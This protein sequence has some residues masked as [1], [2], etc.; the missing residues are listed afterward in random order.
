MADVCGPW[1]LEQLDQFG[2]LDSLPFS[3]DSDVWLTA[4]IRDGSGAVT[5]DGDVTA[6]SLRERTAEAIILASGTVTA[7]G[8]REFIVEGAI[9]ATGDVSASCVR[10]K[11]I[12]TIQD[13]DA[14][15]RMFVV[16]GLE[17]SETVA[18]SADGDVA[19]VLSKI[20]S[21]S[22]AVAALGTVNASAYYYGEEWTNV[23]DETNTWTAAAVQS[24]TWTEITSGN[25][26]WQSVA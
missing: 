24:N 26:S 2:T 11:S 18:I 8:V 20:M 22:G 16:P 7:A 23:G 25:N 10:V 19:A 17:Y 5:A 1:T 12:D 9:S 13:I 6:A 4:C 15:G 21:V 14:Y 3:L